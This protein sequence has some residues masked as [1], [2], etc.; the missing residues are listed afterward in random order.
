[1]GPICKI[2]NFHKIRKH[3]VLTDDNNNNNN[4]QRR[5]NY[6]LRTLVGVIIILIPN[7]DL[8]FKHNSKTLIYLKYIV[9]NKITGDTIIYTP[10]H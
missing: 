3:K 8:S 9:I 1:M 10:G 7:V 5:L 2:S 6:L 4:E